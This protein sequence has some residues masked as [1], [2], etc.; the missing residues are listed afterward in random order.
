MVIL[1]MAFLRY[2][3]RYPVSRER[4]LAIQKIIDNPF[5]GYGY[6]LFP[7]EYVWSSHNGILDILQ[8]AG[9]PM[10]ILFLYFFYVKTSLLVL[11]ICHNE[12]YFFP[13]VLLLYSLIYS[14]SG[15]LIYSSVFWVAVALI[16]SSYYNKNNVNIR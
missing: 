5:L 7:T 6:R 4:S 9:V 14:L 3:G 15:G 1:T 16:C 8:I 11:K 2:F 10:G 12:K 13:S